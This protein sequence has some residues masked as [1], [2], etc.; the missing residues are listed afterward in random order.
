[1]RTIASLSL[2]EVL[3]KKVLIFAAALT[4]VFLGFYG[5]ALH[6]VGVSIRGMGT[7]PIASQIAIFQMFSVGLYIGSFIVAFLAIFS[8]VGSVSS[9][10]EDGSM[11]AIATKPIRR[12]DIV[13]GRF[14]G[15]SLMLAAYAGIYFTCLNLLVLWQLGKPV[16]SGFVPGMLLFMLQ[17]VILLS[18]TILGSTRLTTFA[19][20]I[21][22]IMVYA[23]SIVGGMVEQVGVA[24]KN[25]SLVQAGIIASLIMPA[26]ATYRRMVAVLTPSGDLIA[27]VQQMGPFGAMSRPSNAMLAYTFLYIA[28]VVY[29]AIRSFESR[30]I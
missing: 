1:L 16:S 23:L 6:Y 11:Y 22:V 27:A 2:L 12:R 26:D 24:L 25:E 3:R 4:I 13:A 15:Y 9:E 7:N 20:G 10:I 17:P 19:N 18:V 30:D 28:A 8:A 14:A 29:V 21:V 5:T